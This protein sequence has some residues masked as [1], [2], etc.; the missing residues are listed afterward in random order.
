MRIC[1]HKRTST[2]L[3][4]HVWKL[5]N[6]NINFNIKWEVV[7]KVKPVAHCMH[8]KRFLLH[9]NN[10]SLSIN[11]EVLWTETL[12]LDKNNIGQV[13]LT[14]YIYIYIHIYI[15]IYIYIIIYILLESPR[16]RGIKTLNQYS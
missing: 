9:Y 16:L 4:D 2:T 7:K 10:N 1:E 3:S 5:K 15:Y 11:D 12:S 14:I 6:K 13:L 8:K